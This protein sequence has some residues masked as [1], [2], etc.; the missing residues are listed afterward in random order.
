MILIKIKTWKAPQNYW[1]DLWPQIS[2]LSADVLYTLQSMYQEVNRLAIHA[3]QNK[4]LKQ[5]K[6]FQKSAQVIQASN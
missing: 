5:F 6:Q 3:C 2:V 4:V 1:I